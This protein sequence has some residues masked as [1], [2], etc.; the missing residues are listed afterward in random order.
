MFIGVFSLMC[1]LDALCMYRDI[2]SIQ[3]TSRTPWSRITS[4]LK[5]E[6]SVVGENTITEGTTFKQCFIGNHVKIGSRSKLNN[7]V[8]MDH[9]IIGEK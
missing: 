2:T 6:S 4:Y 7:C 8:I 9:V 1:L 5:K 3:H